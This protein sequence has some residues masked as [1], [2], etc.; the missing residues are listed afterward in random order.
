MFCN[1]VSSCTRQIH[2]LLFYTAKSTRAS[3]SHYSKLAF[4]WGAE[5]GRN[6]HLWAD[7]Q[8]VHHV[9]ESREG[10]FWLILAPIE[11]APGLL[12]SLLMAFVCMARWG[13]GRVRS[14]N[15]S[16]TLIPTPLHEH[17]LGFIVSARRAD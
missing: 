12:S 2:V 7:L 1:C 10:R 15:L 16:Q 17:I 8:F 5:S 6:L 13:H 4:P 3:P 11:L 9:L 14:P